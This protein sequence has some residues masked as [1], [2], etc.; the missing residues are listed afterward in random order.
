MTASATAAARPRRVPD[1]TVVLTFDDGVVSHV[2]HVAPLLKRYGFPAT[3]FICE[4]PGFED[5]ATY[6]SWEQMASLHKMG[7]EVANHTL[8]HKMVDKLTREQFEVELKSL[9][10]KAHALGVP[11]MTSFAYP[12]YA[13]NAMSIE[14]L[15]QRGYRFARAGFERPYDPLKDDPFLIPSFTTKADNRK[16]ILD[17]LK[18]AR[19]GKIVVLT[20]HGVPETAHPWVDTPPDL[21]REYLDFLRDNRYRPVA[22]RDLVRYAPRTA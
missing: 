15:K 17:A 18:S 13:N 5:K 12:S 6:M 20:I 7:F 21:F 22:M 9:E 2:R 3:F 11:R 19:D 8:H 16:D 14:V 1:K 10:D 4:F